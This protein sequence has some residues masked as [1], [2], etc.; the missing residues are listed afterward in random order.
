MVAVQCSRAH[1]ET[2]PRKSS[3]FALTEIRLSSESKNSLV[4]FVKKKQ[5]TSIDARVG[6]QI[7]LR[8]IALDM[9]QEELGKH[10][11]LTFQQV[12]KYEKGVNRIGAG[13]LFELSRIL[14]VGILYFYE[15]LV[16]KRL[17]RPFG[18]AEENAPTA[19]LPQKSEAEQLSS[20]FTRI[21]NTKVRRRIVDLVRDLADS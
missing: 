2:D 9:S 5:A 21:A 19:A 17:G 15:G 1:N 8:R 10:L 20:A 12:Q 13:R 16:D 14:D 6:H 3:L 18:F 4:I 7:R 11:G